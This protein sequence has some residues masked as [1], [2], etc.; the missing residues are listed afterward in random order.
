MKTA[1]VI[2]I[3]AT[4][5]DN[6]YFEINSPAE[7]Y[8]TEAEA[9]AALEA[10]DI[11]N[12]CDCIVNG[13]ADDILMVWVSVARCDYNPENIDGELDACA[14]LSEAEKTTNVYTKEFVLGA[15]EEWYDDNR[16]NECRFGAHP[17]TDAEIKE[18][19][20]ASMTLTDAAGKVIK[21]ETYTRKSDRSEW[22]TA[23][24]RVTRKAVGLAIAQA[25][26]AAGL[27]LRELEALTGIDNGHISRIE[28]GRMNVTL[29]TVAK[30]CEVLGLKIEAVHK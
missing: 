18:G 7:V 1:Y 23:I 13:D 11:N 17:F 2:D 5:Y 10:Y 16:G 22:T 20:G 15:D 14:L 21:S 26:N 25:R 3:E 24:G 27:S 28:G 4:A 12:C 8:E 6:Q 9:L 19:K 29:D 30:L